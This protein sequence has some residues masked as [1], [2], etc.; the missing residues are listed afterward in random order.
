MMR[1]RTTE[2]PPGIETVTHRSSST[3]P[4]NSRTTELPPGIETQ[5][6][7]KIVHLKPSLPH[8]RTSPRD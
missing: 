8:D 5:E 1:S 7:V 2:L 6:S 4:G 3:L